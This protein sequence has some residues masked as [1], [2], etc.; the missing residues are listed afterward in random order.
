MNRFS[1]PSTRRSRTL[2]AALLALA[3]VLGFAAPAV[4]AD[5]CVSSSATLD[6]AL[7]HFAATGEDTTIR[8]AAGE[9]FLQEATL[10]SDGDLT[11]A[12]GYSADCSSRSW[13]PAL[14]VL[15]PGLGDRLGFA[16]RNLSIGSVTLDEID[17]FASFYAA[18]T[19][20]SN[21]VLRLTRVRIDGPAPLGLL[22]H[23]EEVFLS[24][25]IVSNTGSSEAFGGECAVN[26]F[27]PD[28][29]DDVVAIQHSTIVGSPGSGVCIGDHFANADQ[30]F[31]VWIDNN[32]LWGSVVDLDIS[33]T[34]RYVARNN[35]VGGFL[36]EFGPADP[37]ASGGTI[38]ADPL[39]VDAGGFDFRLQDA[40]PA[41]NTGRTATFDGLPQLDIVGNARWIGP[42]PDRGAYESAID[43]TEV[44][45]V[46]D[47]SDLGTPGTLRWALT[48]ANA[49]P[50]VSTIRFDLPGG[51]PRII[52]LSGELPEIVTPIVIDGFSQPGSH[53]NTGGL[54]AGG[55]TDAV[56][57]VWLGTVANQYGLRVPP[58]SAGRLN[59]SGIA[60]GGF[61]NT[62]ISIEGGAGSSLAGVDIF[63]V[64]PIGLFVGGTADATQIG[65]PDP[66]QKNVFRGSSGWNIALNPGSAHALVENNL[67]GLNPDGNSARDDNGVGIG[68]SGSDNTIR[69]NAIAG[70]TSGVAIFDGDRNYIHH[71]TF[72]RKVGFVLCGVPPLPPCERDLPNASHGVLLQGD[73]NDNIVE[74]NEIANSGGAGIRATE[75]QRNFLLANRIWN[76]VGLGIDLNAEGQDPFDNDGDPGAGALANRG[77]NAPAFVEALGGSRTGSVY[78]VLSSTNGTYVA[79]A[80][81]SYDCANDRPQ[82]RFLV[83]LGS[84]TISNAP[85]GESALGLIN[86]RVR[87]PSTAS[88]TGMAI[89]A[90]VSQIDAGGY[91]NTS[92]LSFC[93]PYE[94]DTI[95]EDG[96][97]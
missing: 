49:N 33:A 36:G 8:I 75:G 6:D 9:Y 90:M 74:G 64:Q 31:S 95:F 79:Q 91:G 85:P 59:V 29:G 86:V 67:I 96:F 73:A 37:G 35:I 3:G 58:G 42:A 20:F 47:D 80:Y 5:F 69:Y 16:A 30:H 45:T 4:A 19:A 52:L 46:T 62:A 81:A 7:E 94:D 71:N 26:I 93:A 92:E 97:D 66:W 40:S 21:G 56:Q 12:G 15:R 11:I 2:A 18:G 55:G 76:S 34:S 70:T 61:L 88:L 13:D 60:L 17:A 43:G 68:I 84:V 51:C 63:G 72:G 48:Q 82:A 44:L 28:D 1:D 14:T 77:L 54:I 53:P 83:G 38:T 41:I 89:T 23:G 87:A 32:I 50:N 25:S 22:L 65:G 24:E 27:G 57:C 78:A 39:F 10:N